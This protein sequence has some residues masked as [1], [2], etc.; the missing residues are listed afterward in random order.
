MI[1]LSRSALA[2]IL[3]RDR[4]D[5]RPREAFR[6]VR[7]SDE[8]YLATLA[9]TSPTIRWWDCTTTHARFEW[10][11]FGAQPVTERELDYVATTPAAFVRK[12]E[13]LDEALLAKADALAARPLHEVAPVAPFNPSVRKLTGADHYA[14][15]RDALLAAIP[16][17]S[18]PER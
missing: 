12:M 10:A 14:G 4:I 16:E 9:T 13:S 6:R 1:T 7:I 5:R 11:Y 2:E 8:S 18:P 3:E 17:W 15:E